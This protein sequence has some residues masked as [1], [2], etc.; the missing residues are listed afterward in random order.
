M[1]SNLKRKKIEITLIELTIPNEIY[2]WFHK[3][4]FSLDFTLRE[5]NIFEKE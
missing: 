4:M 1:H 5:K 3:K 2:Y